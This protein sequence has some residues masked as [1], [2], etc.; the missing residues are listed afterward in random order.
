MIKEALFFQG[1]EPFEK[2]SLSWG[3]T[4]GFEFP[5]GKRTSQKKRKETFLHRQLWI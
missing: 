3:G 5:V 4:E 2:R 1:E